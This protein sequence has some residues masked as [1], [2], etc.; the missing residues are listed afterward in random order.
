[1]LF[2]C[3]VCHDALVSVYS[4]LDASS[5]VVQGVRLARRV[6]SCAYPRMLIVGLLRDGVSRMYPQPGGVGC[7]SSFS[8]L[9]SYHSLSPP[10]HLQSE[11]DRDRIDDREKRALGHVGR[12]S[13][14][15]LLH[16]LRALTWLLQLPPGL[17]AAMRPTRI[18]RS[19]VAANGCQAVNGR[20]KGGQAQSLAHK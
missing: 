18:S 5:C 14:F 17:C 8:G 12:K 1:M 3:S 19:E 6:R 11:A 4:V 13:T 15:G 20:A 7:G 10:G 9:A 2:L 16:W